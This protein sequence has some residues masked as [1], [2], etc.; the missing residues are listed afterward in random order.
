MRKAPSST[1]D[2]L[3]R[4]DAQDGIETAPANSS[5][6][7]WRSDRDVRHGPRRAVAATGLAGI[8]LI[9][10][11]DL[12]GKISETPYLG[13]AYI[14]LVVAALVLAEMLLRR[15]DAKVWAATAGLTAAVIAG[16][17][18]NR[19]VGMP[20]ATGDIG[21]WLEPIGLASLAVE[22]FVLLLAV[23]RLTRR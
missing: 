10:V 2:Q 19:T 12:P 16:Y 15:D 9:H 20:N 17:V 7:Q 3:D 13:Y 4:L 21:N 14:G 8:A 18:I 6:N 5:S 23:G 1:I 11:L 22:G